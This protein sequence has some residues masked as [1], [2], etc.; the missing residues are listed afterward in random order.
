MARVRGSPPEARADRRVDDRYEK[1]QGLPRTG[2]RRDCEALTRRGL[3]N[4]LHLVPVKGDRLPID[5]ED[6]GH[7]RMPQS[8]S[9]ERLD[10]SASLEMR[11]EGDQRLGPKAPARIDCINLISDILGTDLRE[12]AGE[13]RVVRNERTIQIKNIHEVF[14]PPRRAYFGPWTWEGRLGLYSA[15]GM[16]SATRLPQTEDQYRRGVELIK[17][18]ARFRRRGRKASPPLAAFGVDGERMSRSP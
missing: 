10:R 11:I 6:A 18:I 3:R 14:A 12:R 4:S 5:P 15:S 8:L 16:R 13:A 1:A 7:I 9:N 17:A 2:A